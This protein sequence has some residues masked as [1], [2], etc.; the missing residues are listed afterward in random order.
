MNLQLRAG[1]HTI[2]LTNP[3]FGVKKELTITLKPGETVTRVLT[4]AP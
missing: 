3:E 4:L 2:I 1:P